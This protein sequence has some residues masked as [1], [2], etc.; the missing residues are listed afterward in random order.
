MDVK[1]AVAAFDSAEA[2]SLAV[3][4]LTDHGRVIGILTEA[5]TLRR[6]AEEFDKHRRDVLGEI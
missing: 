5:H 6:Y 3:V 1:Q 4:D 2:E